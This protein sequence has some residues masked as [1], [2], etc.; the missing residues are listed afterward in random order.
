MVKRSIQFILLILEMLHFSGCGTLSKKDQDVSDPVKF[1]IRNDSSVIFGRLENGFQY[2]LMKND[3]PEERIVTALN[4]EIGSAF[5]EENERGLAHFLEH[6]AFRGSKHFPG[7][8]IVERM[9]KLGIAFGHN[10]NAYTSFLNTC[11]ELNLPNDRDETVDTAFLALRDFCDRLN[12][13]ESDVNQ[14]RGVIL[15]EQRDFD[16]VLMRYAK[17]SFKFFLD[18]TVLPYRFPIGKTK[19]IKRASPK[20]I[21]HFYEKWYAPERMFFVAVGNIDTLKFEERI[22]C[23]FQNLKPKPLPSL[24]LGSLKVQREKFFYFSDPDLSETDVE[25][26]LLF[27]DLFANDTYEARRH[28]I[29]LDIVLNVLKERLLDKRAANPSLFANVGAASIQ[30]CLKTKHTVLNVKITCEHKNWTACLHLL[31]QEMRKIYQ[32][33]ISETELQR[34]KEFF[35]NT[36]ERSVLAAKTRHSSGLVAKLIH[37]Y[38]NK[39]NFMSPEDFC[40]LVK[41]L[42]AEITAED[43][44]KEFAKIWQGTYVSVASNHPIDGEKQTIEAVFNRSKKIPVHPNEQESLGKFAY[45]HFDTPYRTILQ[46]NAIEDLGITQLTLANGVKINLKPTDFR[47]NQVLYALTIGHGMMTAYPHP[48]PGIFLIAIQTFLGSGLK[49]NPWKELS[50][51][52]TSKCIEMKFSADPRSFNFCGACDKKNLPFGLELMAAYLTDAGFEERALFEA[53]EALK[54]IYLDRAKSPTAVI[55]DQYQKFIMGNDR[56]AGLPEEQSVF[57][58]LM[59]DVK[60]LLLPIFQSE[61]IE[62]SI[63]GDF[64]LEMTV[65]NIQ[66]T[67]GTLLPR[68]P[69]PQYTNENVVHFPQAIPEKSLFFTGDEK[70]TVSILTFLTDDENNVSDDRHLIALGEIIGDRLRNKIRKE[71]GKIYSPIVDHNATLFNHFGLFEIMLSLDP[72]LIPDIKNEVLTILE[73]LKTNPISPEELERIRLP[74]LN[75]VRDQFRNNGFWLDHIMH[76]HRRPQCLE[77]L[78]T[79]RPFYENV[80]P[81]A[82]LEIAQKYLHNPVHTTISRQSSS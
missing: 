24:E 59:D 64:D 42:N 80:T 21:R 16:N 12:I 30:D 78:R 32:Y 2:A 3:Y 6:M 35:T 74:I 36:A 29:I 9:Q 41:Q 44:Q 53:R 14:E 49:K 60:K 51:L 79:M 13:S 46:R 76:A 37:C 23:T 73:D 47:Q 38:H 48:Q 39:L 72:D 56:I 52:I 28:R 11:Y 77:N 45:E 67:F 57:S 27:P 81:Q 61:A 71:E 4:F 1:E 55:E 63:V 82:L 50:K 18:G 66:N 31:E 33:G 20:D 10:L 40:A 5:E 22:R 43:C 25:I 17:K 65:Q 62:L 19:V 34:Q 8:E 7:G 70:R 75:T 26:T 58:V 54:P 15:A 69:S 68:S